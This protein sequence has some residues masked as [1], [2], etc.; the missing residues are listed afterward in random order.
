MPALERLLLTAA[1]TILSEPGRCYTVHILIDGLDEIE[2]EKQRQVVKLMSKI[3]HSARSGCTMFKVLISCRM[4]P[5][6]EKLLQRKSI[7]S[8]GEEKEALE[9]AVGIYASQRL[10]ADKYRLAQLSINDSDISNFARIIARKA[11]G[12]TPNRTWNIA[13][14]LLI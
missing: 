8:L 3:T 12:I 1:T 14:R 9:N 6:L 5:L 13:T 10:E 11:D 7:V 2:A 4:S